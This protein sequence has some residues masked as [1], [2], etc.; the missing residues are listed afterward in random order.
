M[1][2]EASLGAQYELCT[3]EDASWAIERQRP[4]PVAPFEQPVRI[5]EG[6]FAEIPRAYVHSTRDR[7]IPPA[8]QL[9]MIAENG[10]TDA[11]RD[12]G[13]P[14]SAALAARGAGRGDRQAGRRRPRATA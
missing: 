12:R 2:P 6:A 11:G 8:L 10:I 7:S 1:P 14:H 9:R 4:Q 3:P 13:R 5:P